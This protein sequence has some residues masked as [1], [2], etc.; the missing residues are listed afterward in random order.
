MEM[1]DCHTAGS[2][3]SAISLNYIENIDIQGPPRQLP[4]VVTLI[5]PKNLA[6]AI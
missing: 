6:V 4:S 1:A 2:S 3:R 5:E